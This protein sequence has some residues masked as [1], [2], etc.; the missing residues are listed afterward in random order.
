MTSLL[1]LLNNPL[2]L[3]L[4][5]A[6]VWY[7]TRD[8][9]AFTSVI[10]GF[11]TLQ[12]ILEKIVY[13]KVPTFLFGS[14]CFLIPLGAMT[15]IIRDPAFLQWKFTIVHWLFGLILIGAQIIGKKDI[16]KSL[17]SAAGPEV[18]NI[19]D[20]FWRRVNFY[21]A[22]GFILLGFINLYIMR[23]YSFDLWVNFK[24][25]GVLIYNL[26]LTSTAFA[27]LF[28]NAKKSSNLDSNKDEIQA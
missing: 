26:I 28:Y 4:V 22:F 20:I 3:L 14:W 6:G 2:T 9:V 18:R 23:F 10:M 15:L 8:F 25:Y 13:G 7:T 1:K 12:V 17:L 19:D 11:V 5:F 24:L 16:L 27:Y 21:M